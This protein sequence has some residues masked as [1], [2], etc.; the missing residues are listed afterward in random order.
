MIEIIIALLGIAVIAFIL[1][2]NKTSSKQSYYP[3]TVPV[4]V[5]KT[6]PD[7]AVGFGYK[8]MWFAVN[9]DN[10]KR[11]AERGAVYREKNAIQI[12]TK[13]STITAYR[14]ALKTGRA[15]RG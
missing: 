15:F 1:Y 4:T 9:T 7:S 2:K 6:I 14:D 11:I 5:D 10:K 3:S 8:C 12:K 13:K